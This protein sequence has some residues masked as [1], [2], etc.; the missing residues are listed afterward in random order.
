M[1]KKQKSIKPNS[2]S[3]RNKVV[4]GEKHSTSQL[5]VVWRFDKL[6][7][8]GH[9]AFDITRDDF[10]HREVLDKIISYSSMT[11][12]DIQS[13]THDRGKSKHHFLSLDSLSSEAVSR[14][15]AKKFDDKTEQ[16]FSFALQNKL[17]VIGF[18]DGQYFYAVWYDPNHEFCP[19]STR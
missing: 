13:Q 1:S 7:R 17:R 16:L 14:I 11:W 3:S 12:S 8:S 5:N 19:S 6:D 4:P 15:T 18:R 10:Q 2:R 9:F